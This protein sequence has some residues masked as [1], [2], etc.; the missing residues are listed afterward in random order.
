[1][2]VLTTTL[3]AFTSVRLCDLPPG[4]ASA[5]LQIYLCQAGFYQGEIDGLLGPR[6]LIAYAEFKRS[7]GLSGDQLNPNSYHRLV[8]L[9]LLETTARPTPP[10][11]PLLLSIRI[12]PWA[13]LE[14][15]RGLV[16][17]AVGYAEGSRSIQGT[18]LNTT[19]RTASAASK[20]EPKRLE[21]LR[22]QL[23]PEYC[24]IAKA[25]RLD[26]T[27]ALLFLTFC[28]LYSQSPNAVLVEGGLLDQLSE[29][30]EFGVSL[31]TLVAARVRSWYE[32]DGLMN[33]MDYRYAPGKLRAEQQR[34]TDAV[35]AVLALTLA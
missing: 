18:W 6:S 21:R 4:P 19:A 8:H 16:S 20:A 30:A 33:S 32:P 13:E 25:A 31:K 24:A 23:W 27:Q 22:S 12:D 7:Q 15:S 17:R 34:R 29:L 35:S 3:N 14:N 28:D 5:Q 1:M 26:P 2:D 10:L 9:A 11:E